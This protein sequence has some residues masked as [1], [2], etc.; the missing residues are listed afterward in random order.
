M[1]IRFALAIGRLILSVGAPLVVAAG[2]ASC[3]DPGAGADA[4]PTRI[5]LITLDTLRFDGFSPELMPETYRLME[6][7]HVFSRFYSST[8]TTQPTH[9]TILTGLHPWEHGVT[10]NGLVLGQHFDLLPEVL[11]DEGYWTS[12]IV[13]SYPL[14]GSFGYD[15]GF[16]EF[17]DEF[18]VDYSRTWVGEEVEGGGFY[19]LGED[20]AARARAA[21][22]AAPIGPQFFW[23]HFF[24][25]HDPY[26]DTPSGEGEVVV[27]LPALRYLGEKGDPTFADWLPRARA[28]YERDIQDLD[29]HLAGLIQSILADEAFET[30]VILTADHGE[31]FGEDSSLGHGDRVSPSQVHVPMAILAPTVTGTDPAARL[32]V[33][34]SVDLAA[35]VAHIAGLTG[36]PFGGRSLVER[37][38]S[39]WPAAGTGAAFGMRRLLP[40]D[41]VELRLD[42]S[43]HVQS[44][45]VFYAH[46]KGRLI[47]GNSED[48]RPADPAAESPSGGP[49]S[50]ESL[51]DEE[52]IRALFAAFEASLEGAGAEELDSSAARD[53]LGALGYGR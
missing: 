16:D 26:G 42:G 40:E 13:T 45:P 44:Q 9:A 41:K 46:H 38:G 15:Q 5:A 39:S 14:K 48:A 21:V 8:S 11:Q 53:A 34:G 52:K 17:D 2:A 7:G 19:S 12:A 32:D 37:N 25:P 31:S 35:T 24:D 3:G 47:E 10:R 6:R 30:S 27:Q 33:A 18:G 1:D 20:A 50:A 51:P 23:F 4:R 49:A 29:R 28:Q 22:A 36:T 43:E